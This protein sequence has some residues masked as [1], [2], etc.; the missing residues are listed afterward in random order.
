MKLGIVFMLL[1]V[2]LGWGFDVPVGQAAEGLDRW[3]GLWDETLKAHVKDG[4]VDY[5][6]L[7]VD[8]RVKD[9]WT[10]AQEWDPDKLVTDEEKMSAW[11]N[12]YNAFNVKVICEGYPA[13]S[14]NDLQFGGM[15]T[16]AIFGKT[17]WD[18]PVVVLAN[19]KLNLKTIDHQ[20]LRKEFNE[21]RLQFGLACGAVSCPPLRSEAYRAEKISQQLEDQARVFF[22][23]VTNNRFDVSLKTAT[24][25]SIMKW[26]AKYFG[27]NEAA[28]LRFIAQ[29]LP[30]ETGE[31]LASDPSSWKINYGDYDLTINDAQPTVAQ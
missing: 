7:C 20:I 5:V 8:Q 14:I 21:P 9:F 10:Q 2:A 30:Q 17:I 1:V 15:M 6:N 27:S 28:V 16:A 11:L 19:K 23:D 18:R 24:I 29:F 31:A 3:I 26:N 25:S 22:S 12:I 4:R 13:K